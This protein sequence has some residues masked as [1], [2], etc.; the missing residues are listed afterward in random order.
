MWGTAVEGQDPIGYPASKQ[1][2]SGPVKIAQEGLALANRELIGAAGH[3]RMI[4]VEGS[5]SPVIRDPGDLWSTIAAD[6]PITQ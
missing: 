1:Q 3:E 2:F 6:A 5:Q 4:D